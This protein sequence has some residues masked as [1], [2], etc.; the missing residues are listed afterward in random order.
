MSANVLHFRS[1]FLGATE[2]FIA[3]TLRALDRGGRFAPYVLCRRLVEPHPLSPDRVRALESRAGD[4]PRAAGWRGRLAQRLLPGPAAVS[5]DAGAE[6]WLRDL[7]PALLHAHFGYDGWAALPVAEALDIP[8]LVTFYGHDL[9]VYPRRWIWRHRYRRLFERADR[10]LAEGAHMLQTLRELGCPAQ[11]L[12]MLRNPLP[13]HLSGFRAR[14]WKDATV[15]A[16]RLLLVGRFVEKKGHVHAL[17]ALAALRREFPKLELELVGDGPLRGEIE[18]EVKR[19][20]LGDAVALRG[21]LPAASLPDRFE[22]AD[23][24]VAPSVR[25]RNGDHEGGAPNV[26]LDAQAAGLPVVATRHRDIPEFVVPDESAL[27]APEGDAR[28]LADCLRSL[29]SKDGGLS[30]EQMGRSGRAHVER[31]FHADRV[32]AQ[33]QSIYEA[34]LVGR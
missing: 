17:R 2:T 5:L 10:C 30:W 9:A 31:T 14:P 29:L 32:L 33:L 21:M 16:V 8:L 19:L 26:L 24:L 12:R 28:A 11:K 4:A 6:H 7:R 3:R 34:L 1:D 20:G 22:A 27:L 25:A 23:V 13:E 15:E 18:A